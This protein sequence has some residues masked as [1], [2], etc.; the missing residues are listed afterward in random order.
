MASTINENQTPWNIFQSPPPQPPGQPHRQSASTNT[1]MTNTSTSSNTSMP[2][3]I[4]YSPQPTTR[5]PSMRSCLHVSIS[6]S[7]TR[8]GVL[9]RGAGCTDALYVPL[10]GTGAGACVLI[11]KMTVTSLAQ[12]V[13]LALSDCRM[14]MQCH[15]LSLT[16]FRVLLA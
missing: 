5:D 2:E 1:S 4:R 6:S 9:G 15:I 14:S 16:K 10:V 11:L 12:S 13:S 8:V 7:R 3:T